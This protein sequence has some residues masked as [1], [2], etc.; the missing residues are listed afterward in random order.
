MKKPRNIYDLDKKE[1]KQLMTDLGQPSYRA[2][3]VWHW[4]YDQ[5]VTDFMAMTNIPLELRQELLDHVEIL[6][7]EPVTEQISKDGQTKKVLFEL[8][9]GNF[10]ETVLMRYHSRRTLC[11]ST[12]AG[13]AMGCVFCATGQMGFFRN[14]S[15]GEI[16]QQVMFFAR[17]LLDQ[18][19]RVTN[20]VMMG[21]GEPL[22]NYE[23][24]LSAV[25]ILTDDQGFNLGARKITISTV[26]LVP[27][28]RRYA[29]EGRQ[30][31]L[32]VSLHAAT[33]KERN[34]LIPISQRWPLA[35]LIDACHYYVSKTGRRITFEWAL[36][37]GENDTQNQARLL[38]QLVKGLLCHV[39]LIPLNPTA[40]YGGQPPSRE[41]VEAFQK[42][43]SRHGV[44]S[45]V[46]VRRG[47]DIQAGCGQLR[48]R[49]ASQAAEPSA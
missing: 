15:A 48:D 26:G 7:W 16:V 10:I 36:I 14:L 21:M 35:E 20:I 42:E 28:I 25:D 47:I 31:P 30:T 38:G 34:E 12:Q 2:D 49:I 37:E 17:E 5:C 27:A 22:H 46:R 4:L 24:S 1:L 6:P 3:Q 8:A 13:C 44:S 43:L 18:G 23:N 39:N 11:I 45:T 41:R 40:G 29:D 32:A 9:D 33:D 19:E